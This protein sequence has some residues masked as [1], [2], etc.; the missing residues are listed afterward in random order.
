MGKAELSVRTA[1][2]RT[3]SLVQIRRTVAAPKISGT[4]VCVLLASI[5]RSSMDP[6]SGCGAKTVDLLMSDSVSA[7]H[8]GPCFAVPCLESAA[9]DMLTIVQPFHC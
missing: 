1:K 8:N 7:D 5:P 6:G 9:L 4:H 3:R 2:A